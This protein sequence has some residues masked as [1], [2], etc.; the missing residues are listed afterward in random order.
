LLRAVRQLTRLEVVLF[1][2]DFNR[3]NRLTVTR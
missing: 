2:I 1:G 3:I